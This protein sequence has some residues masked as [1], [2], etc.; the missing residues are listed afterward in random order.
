MVIH[1]TKAKI[2]TSLELNPS[3]PIAGT[4]RDACE[5]LNKKDL[6]ISETID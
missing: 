3:M 2:I 4:F 6:L 5:I 1:T